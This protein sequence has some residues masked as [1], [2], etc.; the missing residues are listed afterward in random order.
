M[1]A[2]IVIAHDDQ[3]FREFVAAALQA[4]G[5]EIMAFAGSMAA[6]AA[7]E[8]AER[9]ELLITRVGFPEGTPNGV[10]L[11]RMTRVKKPD[12]RVLFA[13][14]GENREHTE[15]LGEFLTVPVSGPEVLATVE[16]ML[17]ETHDG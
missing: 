16:R 4:A 14:R 3:E 12:V 6:L 13:A 11:A 15:G 2:R 8:T 9:I 1:P 17:A 5:Y 10:A 7:L